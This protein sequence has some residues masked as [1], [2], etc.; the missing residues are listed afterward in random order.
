MNY[1]KKNGNKK[2]SRDKRKVKREQEEIITQKNKM[3]STKFLYRKML[4]VSL[5]SSKT[6]D[7]GRD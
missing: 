5:I 4:E 1:C 6:E 3:I 2:T 7:S